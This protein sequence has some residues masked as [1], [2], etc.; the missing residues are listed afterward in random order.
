MHA[1][2]SQ[3][4]S[5]SFR[6]SLRLGVALL[7]ENEKFGAQP[8]LPFTD[9]W[10][11]VEKGEYEL[12]YMPNTIAVKALYIWYEPPGGREEE[13]EPLPGSP[14]AVSVRASRAD[15]EATERE[16]MESMMIVGISAGDYKVTPNVFAAA[17]AKWGECTVDAFASE[18]TALLPRFWTATGVRK[19]EA[20]NAL[21]QPWTAGERL[22]MHPPIELLSAV[23]KK[24][25]GPT[26][27]AEI[28]LLAPIHRG[29]PWYPEILAMSDDTLKFP[30]GNL[31]KIADD[32]PGRLLEWPMEVF[33]IPAIVS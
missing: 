24:L 14:F 18:A 17:Q 13:R 23:V 5:E 12:R 7:K 31:E 20:T 30:K 9:S 29:S 1:R 27:T 10:D 28:V 21:A 11:G 4:P 15:A 3:V 26:R 19:A 32:A 16:R 2:V 25:K 6:A 22:W 33:H 8:S